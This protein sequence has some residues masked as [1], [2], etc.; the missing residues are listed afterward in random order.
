MTNTHKQAFVETLNKM[1]QAEENVKAQAENVKGE[2][3]SLKN[4]G[5]SLMETLVEAITNGE[6]DAEYMEN[7]PKQSRVTQSYLSRGK[8]V[9][10]A[11]KA[12]TIQKENRSI[13]RLYD[14]IQEQEKTD[15]ESKKIQGAANAKVYAAILAA[16]DNDKAE[17][18]RIMSDVANPEYVIHLQSGLAILAEQE[19]A[20][21][22]KVRAE[23]M[24]KFVT[25]TKAALAEI[26]ETEFWAEIA[27]EFTRL[28]GEVRKAA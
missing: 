17:A 15:K 20:E 14:L 4:I 21:A 2:K 18:D 26:A 10:F 5:V 24:G 25:E 22:A 27:A 8:K 19:A 1:Q 7:L 12:G 28:N 9:G 6:I 11:L 3:D 23:N 16:C 13:L